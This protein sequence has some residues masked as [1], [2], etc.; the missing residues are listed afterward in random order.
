MNP[1]PKPTT[2]R[3]PQHGGKVIRVRVNEVEYARW[4]EAATSRGLSLGDFVRSLT[5]SGGAP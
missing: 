1:G 3:S 2:L 5:P 4:Q